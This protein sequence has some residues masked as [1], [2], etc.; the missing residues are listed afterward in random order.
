MNSS[1]PQ[2]SVDQEK[3]EEGEDGSSLDAPLTVTRPPNSTLAG[4]EEGLNGGK[5]DDGLSLDTPVTGELDHSVEVDKEEEDGPGDPT[6]EAE[7]DHSVN[8]EEGSHTV[9]PPDSSTVE[10][11][12]KEEGGD[13]S[14]QV[15][16]PIS[17]N[18]LE[19]KVEGTGQPLNE[20]EGAETSVEL[21]R[22]AD[23]LSGDRKGGEQVDR[24]E[25]GEDGLTAEAPARLPNSTLKEE[26]E[27]EEGENGG[28]ERGREDNTGEGGEGEEGEDGEDGGKERG[29]EDNTGEG[30]KGEEGKDGGKE[31]GREDNTGEGEDVAPTI[32]SEVQPTSDVA[33]LT[34]RLTQDT[35]SSSQVGALKLADKG[36][37]CN[38]GA[39][40]GEPLQCKGRCSLN[41]ILHV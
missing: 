22:S 4:E 28:K 31:R 11:G 10:E 39:E 30:G 17:T 24:E 12:S 7:R 33:D 40:K 36:I 1:R 38:G 21:C 6:V 32:S 25:E 15:A 35:D 16:P 20:D 3:E 13:D 29:R 9:V 2:E 27:G 37:V 14:P 19:S 8:E 34:S 26:D 18:P 23:S 5:L 41:R